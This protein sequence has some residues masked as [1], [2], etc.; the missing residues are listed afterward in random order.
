[1]SCVLE[2]GH[3]LRHN[4]I[5]TREKRRLVEAI[6][7]A[8]RQSAA[9]FE[10]FSKLHDTLQAAARHPDILDWE[11]RREEAESRELEER[12]VFDREL[13]YAMQS[14]ERLAATIERYR[15]NFDG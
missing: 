2:E 8:P 13:F 9:R 11:R 3:R 7:A 4:V 10:L 15:A 12:V 14:R 6:A 1:M 5:E